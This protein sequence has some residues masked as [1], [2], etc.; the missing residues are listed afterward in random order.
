MTTGE[1]QLVDK[2]ISDLANSTPMTTGEN[3]LVDKLIS[4]FA[5]NVAESGIE[6]LMETTFS[7]ELAKYAWRTDDWIW[8]ARAFK[9]W[10]AFKWMPVGSV[11]WSAGTELYVTRD[12]N[13]HWTERW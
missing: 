1:N 10:K 7:K 6:T 8:G 3:Q 12:D 5:G 11:A 2:L 13:M 4:D 9:G